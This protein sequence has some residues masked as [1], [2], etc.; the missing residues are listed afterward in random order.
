[1][2]TADTTSIVEYNSKTKVY[3]RKLALIVG[4]TTI[5]AYKYCGLHKGKPGRIEVPKAET[6][7]R[8]KYSKGIWKVM[9]QDSTLNKFNM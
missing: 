6:S 2:Q 9:G 3:F 5:K 7:S 1:V 4:K 8:G